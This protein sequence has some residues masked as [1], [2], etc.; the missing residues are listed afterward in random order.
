MRPLGEDHC[1]IFC[2]NQGRLFEFF[3]SIFALS[4]STMIVR[5]I[6]CDS[7]PVR[8][9]Y[10]KTVPDPYPQPEPA[11]SC[12]PTRPR[13]H[14]KPA[15]T[16]HLPAFKNWKNSKG[17]W[18]RSSPHLCWV[19]SQVTSGLPA[20][21][22]NRELFPRNPTTICGFSGYPTWCRTLVCDTYYYGLF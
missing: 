8:V 2:S 10:L 1:F 20:Q 4:P 19:P 22:R 16:S 7:R 21:P 6:V 12:Y 11:C 13:G 3:F 18:E 9:H 14:T 15:E 5:M 17:G